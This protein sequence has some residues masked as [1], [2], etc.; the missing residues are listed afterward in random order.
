MWPAPKEAVKILTGTQFCGPQICVLSVFCMFLPAKEIFWRKHSFSISPDLY[1]L[2]NISEGS[3][4]I[5]NPSLILPLRKQK[6]HDGKHFP[7][8]AYAVLRV[9]RHIVLK[10]IPTKDWVPFIQARFASKG[11]YRQNRWTYNYRRP[12]PR[13]WLASEKLFPDIG[14]CTYPASF[15]FPPLFHGGRIPAI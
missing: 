1:P 4:N 11:T 3:G 5:N 10:P 7:K 8:Q 6:T 15:R 9:R 14:N 12:S 13:F 2:R